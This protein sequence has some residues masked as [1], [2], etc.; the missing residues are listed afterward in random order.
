MQV[1]S[2]TNKLLDASTSFE[3]INGVQG[4]VLN[5]RSGHKNSFG[6]RNEDYFEALDLILSR[7][8]RVQVKTINVS[9]E[10][11]EAKKIWPTYNERL[12][13]IDDSSEINIQ[14]YNSTDLRKKITNAQSQKK[15]NSLSVGGNPTKRIFI[16]AL[17][18]EVN[19]AAIIRPTNIDLISDIDISIDQNA[20]NPENVRDANKRTL[21]SITIRRGQKKFRD[22]LIKEYEGKCAISGTNVEAVLQAAHIYPYNGQET[23]HVT[24]GILLRAD[25]HDLFDLNLLGIDENYTII[26]GAPLKGTEYDNYN[27]KKIFIPNNL[28]CLPS[29]KALKWRP[30]PNRVES[31]TSE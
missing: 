25:I 30:L 22:K 9:L 11:S 12:L 2:D 10:S 19:W 13:L 15:K 6:L 1:L 20:F 4:L 18:K 5:A 27:G 8:K 29:L 16:S 24:N 7:L 17:D 3:N 14:G 31:N 28:N 23:N 21:T 26:I